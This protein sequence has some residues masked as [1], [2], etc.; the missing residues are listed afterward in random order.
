MS[1][2]FSGES[3]QKPCIGGALFSP[4]FCLFMKRVFEGEQVRTDVNDF[5]FLE[6]KRNTSYFLLRTPCFVVPSLTTASQA[7]ATP[8]QCAKAAVD[9]DASSSRYMVVNYY[10]VVSCERNGLLVYDEFEGFNGMDVRC[11]RSCLYDVEVPVEHQEFYRHGVKCL[12]LNARVP[13]EYEVSMENGTLVRD[14]MFYKVFGD[15][16]YI[17]RNDRILYKFH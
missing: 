13:G 14:G 4:R 11:V 7:M 12:A 10:K 8:N 3:V 15:G 6:I 5:D 16:R 1:W 17:F 2:M 9:E